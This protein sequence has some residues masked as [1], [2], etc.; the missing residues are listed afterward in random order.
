MPDEIWVPY[1]S[2]PY[3]T[4]PKSRFFHAGDFF[5]ILKKVRVLNVRGVYGSGKTLSCALIAREFVSLGLVNHIWANFPMRYA[6]MILPPLNDGVFILDE[7]AEVLD[8]RKFASNDTTSYLQ[9]MR[10]WHIYLLA[11]SVIALDSR[12]RA[13]SVQRVLGFPRFWA[14]RYFFEM[15]SNSDQGWFVIL[16]PESAFSMYDTSSETG[17]VQDGGFADAMNLT[18]AI[19]RSAMIDW[20]GRTF[21]LPWFDLQTGKY[22]PNSTPISYAALEDARESFYNA[23]K[24]K[25]RSSGISD[26]AGLA[27]ESFRVGSGSYPG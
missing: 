12:L 3:A 4:P 20:D 8:A 1:D 9:Y 7:A 13:L 19:K 10:K 21:Y 5:G 14:Y 11:P 17:V 23:T 15:G 27:A 26:G 18:I 16:H 2:N 25:S 24:K 22:K 6:E